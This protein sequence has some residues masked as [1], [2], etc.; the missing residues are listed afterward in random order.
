MHRIWNSKVS[1]FDY[2]R[3]AS[4]DY[5]SRNAILESFAIKGLHGEKT[6]SFRTES[7]ATILMARNGSG[8]TTLL[9]AINSVLTERFHRLSEIN[10]ENIEFKF[11]GR[12]TQNL[13]KKDIDQFTDREEM[14]ELVKISNDENIPLDML[15]DVCQV[16]A[17]ISDLSELRRHPGL[18]RIYR[19]CPSYGYRALHS[20]L[21]QFVER[22]YAAL[23]SLK[24]AAEDVSEALLGYDI[25]YLPTYRRIEMPWTKFSSSSQF[26]GRYRAPRTRAPEAQPE[27]LNFGLGD[28]ADKLEEIASRIEGLSSAMYQRIS[29]NII[30]DLLDGSYLIDVRNSEK[31]VRE[32]LALFFERVRSPRYRSVSDFNPPD[33]DR[34]YSED[35]GEAERPFLLYFLSSLNEAIKTTQ[36]LEDR[37]KGFEAVCNKY[38]AD[39]DYTAYTEGSVGPISSDRKRL[40]LS[41]DK[42]RPQLRTSAGDKT[43]RID[44][45]SSGEK[46]VV[47]LF[48]R[49]YLYEKKKIVLFD[50]PELSL[51]IGWQSQLLPDLCASPDFSQLI[52]ITHSPFVFEN[53]LDEFAAN[54]TVARYS[55]EDPEFEFNIDDIDDFLDD[56]DVNLDDEK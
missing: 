30:N 17:Q 14:S 39:E 1:N 54:L 49:M 43:V 48:A 46:Q 12:P 10:F 53:D 40:Q 44:A 55:R 27:E 26:L 33:L 56:L 7:S 29:A 5:L 36:P 34:I 24:E 50:E 9:S 4:K 22:R 42:F 13:S 41:R 8:K 28:I 32:D 21:T 23:P 3:Q 20:T 52:A 45:L 15:L 25:V 19:L 51:S 11:T 35:V 6:V 47:S 18:N 16:V 37:V 2:E 31:P 38:L